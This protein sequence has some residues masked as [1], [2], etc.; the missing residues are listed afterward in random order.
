MLA[1]KPT[2]AKANLKISR[3]HRHQ[4]QS[5]VP[6]LSLCVLVCVCA[7]Y[8]SDTCAA[9]ACS[10]AS[11]SSTSAA[12]AAIDCCHRSMLALSFAI[13]V[14]PFAVVVVAAS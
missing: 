3:T 14:V 1:C 2:A 12:A 10:S 9:S 5:D 4:V 13:V 11:S 8:L 6:P 7:K